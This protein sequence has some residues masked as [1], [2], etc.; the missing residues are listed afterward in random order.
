MGFDIV[1]VGRDKGKLDEVR[2]KIDTGSTIII[3]DFG[4]MTTYEEY[5]QIFS[6]LKKLNIGILVNNAGISYEG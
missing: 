2:D 3:A 1:L 6:P 5:E 4:K